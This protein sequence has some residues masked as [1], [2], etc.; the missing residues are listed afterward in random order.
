M[1]EGL[2]LSE[3][4]GETDYCE[5]TKGLHKRLKLTKG[6]LSMTVEIELGKDW[7]R[8]FK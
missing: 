3:M 8:Y 2:M 5:R 1:A 4:S 7:A 6:I